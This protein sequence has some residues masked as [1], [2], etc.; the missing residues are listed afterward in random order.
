MG[1]QVRDAETVTVA[2]DH[3]LLWASIVVDPDTYDPYGWKQIPWARLQP[4]R[5]ASIASL[6]DLAWGLLTLSAA[7]L[8]AY[9]GALLAAYVSQWAPLPPC[10]PDAVLHQDDL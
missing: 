1:V 10:D 2:P 3:S 7:S 4:T 5:L 6:A 8:D 9:V